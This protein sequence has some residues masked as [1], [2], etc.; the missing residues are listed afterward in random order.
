[1]DPVSRRDA[2]RTTGAGLLASVAG[3]LGGS[4]SPPSSDDTTTDENGTETD[5][6]GTNR[7]VDHASI[8]FA[9]ETA[10][11]EWYA[12]TD[13]AVGNVTVIDS[14]ERAQV[15]WPHDDVPQD[16][17]EEVA[18]FLGEVSFEDSVLLYLE[19]VGPNTCHDA[20][21]ATSVAFEDGELTA[22]A[23]VV[24]TSDADE[25]CGEALTFPSAL[26]RATFSEEPPT[27]AT[28]TVVDGWG[29]EAE[30]S[31]SATDS[32]SPDPD[33]LPGYVRPDGDPEHVPDALACETEG[34]ERVQSWANEGGI[35]WGE[36]LGEGGEPSFALRVDDR[37]V[38]LGETVQITMTNVTDERLTTGNRHKYAF[39]VYTENGWE[40]VRVRPEDRPLEFT[41]EGVVHAPGEGFEWTFELTEEGIVDGHYHED[42]LDVCPDL[43]PGR[44]RFVYWEPNIAVA[45][46]VTE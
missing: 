6:E 16:R 20:I 1:M 30:L 24:D 10:A 8:Q 23:T 15:V 45:F 36:V 39:E 28:V 32:L 40:D 17:R 42:T 26:L 34:V 44:Y 41:D 35:G 19:S 3:C 5:D 27:E 43:S 37:E 22:T 2:L 12:E 21:E 7:L 13:D 25:G 31:A 29:N 33:E 18:D 11:P 46:D 4:E 9:T 38:A 14:E